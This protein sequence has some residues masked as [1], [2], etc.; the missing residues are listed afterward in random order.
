MNSQGIAEDAK[1]RRVCLTLDGD[2]CLWYKSITPW[3]VIGT[4][5]ID[6]YAENSLNWDKHKQN[7][8][9]DGHPFSLM[10]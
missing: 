6:F 7:Y 10:R 1:C 3:A 4:F 5:C 8:F 9:K 2:V